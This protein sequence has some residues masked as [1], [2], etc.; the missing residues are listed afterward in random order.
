[1]ENTEKF[2]GKTNG[3]ILF[4]LLG[5]DRHTDEL[6]DIIDNKFDKTS[7]ELIKENT[8][9]QIQSIEED[10]RKYSLVKMLENMGNDET[11]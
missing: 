3:I 9:K 11:Y 8:I 7:F 5:G 2:R 1:M 10:T 6:K 4:I